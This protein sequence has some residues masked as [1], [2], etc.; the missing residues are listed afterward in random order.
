MELTE[1][2]DGY[3]Q[4]LLP[5]GRLETSGAHD[6]ERRLLTLVG[7]GHRFFVVDLSKVEHVSSEGL[8]VVLMV[9]RR[10]EAIGGRLVLCSAGP[11]VAAAIS[12]TGLGDQ[13]EVVEAREHA[14]ARLPIGA[15]A[16]AMA[17][18]VALLVA[19]REEFDQVEGAAEGWLADRVM[20][21]LAAEIEADS[22]TGAAS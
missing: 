9:S 3:C 11:R 14:M 4:I 18:R 6:L 12:V 2:H 20:Q 17:G 1:L 22:A 13:F 5:S 7:E 15:S 10:L 19:D 8:R 21:L 16:S